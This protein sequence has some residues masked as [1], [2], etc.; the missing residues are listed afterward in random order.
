MRQVT[1]PGRWAYAV[2]GL[3]VIAAIAI[4]GGRLIIR[5]GAHSDQLTAVP[6]RTVSIAQRVTSVS[7]RSLG[8]IISV[9]GGPV[10]RVQIT[11]AIR[12]TDGGPVPGRDPVR[13]SL[14]N[15]RLS[16]D[17]QACAPSL[18][19]VGFSLTVPEDVA[20]T[21]SS[22]GGPMV[23]SGVA[24]ASL[25]SGSGLVHA[26][27][28]RGALIVNSDSGPIMVSG[29]GG[30]NLDSGGGPIGVTGA[31]GPLTVSTAG[32]AL[33]LDGLSGPLNA[34][35]GGG[36]VLARDVAAVTATVDTEGG[37]ASI[38]FTTAPQAVTVNSGGGMARIGFA[39]APRSVTVS[40]AGGP[41]VLVVPGGP[42][43][44]TA[45]AVGG[46]QRVSIPISLAANR[47]ISVTTGGGSLLIEP[48]TGLT[49]G[50][51]PPLPRT[52]TPPG[53]QPV[54]AVPL[55]RDGVRA[56]AGG[57]AWGRSG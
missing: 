23:V 3:V 43:A 29:I 48:G 52:P 36:P 53:A 45:N 15:G 6:T 11:E 27:N 28:I 14:S 32:G 18:C 54:P 47:T 20:V 39:A 41:A 51:V 40:T 56:G 7:V 19:D 57:V 44:L 49:Q 2:S 4:P 30:A 1:A 38:G 8:T 33:T 9:T 16:L 42:Y 55:C 35:T 37:D 34:N 31:R 24:A 17:D 22:E 21:A 26:W 46:A 25:D 5:A 13:Q 50:R 10:N 12:Y